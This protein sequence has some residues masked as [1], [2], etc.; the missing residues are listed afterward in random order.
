[1]ILAVARNENVEAALKRYGEG[2]ENLK[3]AIQQI[4]AG[5]RNA[6]KLYEPLTYDDAPIITAILEGIKRAESLKWFE[7]D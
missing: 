1:M 3:I 2:W 7:Q 6:D 5:E 4:L